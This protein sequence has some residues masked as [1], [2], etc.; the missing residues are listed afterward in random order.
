M[1]ADSKQELCIVVYDMYGMLVDFEY[2]AALEPCI[3]DS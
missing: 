3:Y 1:K 2:G